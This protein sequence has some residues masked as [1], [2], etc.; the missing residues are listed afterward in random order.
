MSVRQPGH[1]QNSIY[2]PLTTVLYDTIWCHKFKS[3]LYM[4]KFD[5]MEKYI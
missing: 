1:M 5:Y 3:V 4:Y 2:I